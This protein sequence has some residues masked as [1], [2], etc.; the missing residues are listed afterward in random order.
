MWEEAH[1]A[2]VFLQE[3]QEDT[4][5]HRLPGYLNS[6][7]TVTLGKR[8]NFSVFIKCDNSSTHTL[9]VSVA[10]EWVSLGKAWHVTS[11]RAGYYL[12]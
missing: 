4:V 5:V 9:R 6:P 12:H 1:S 11:D 7:L 3:P 8:L 10:A 2:Q